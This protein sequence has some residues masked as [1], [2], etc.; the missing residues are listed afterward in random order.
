[1]RLLDESFARPGAVLAL[2]TSMALA[3][4]GC[5]M[6]GGSDRP[7]ASL[8]AGANAASQTANGPSA[9][10][11]VVLGD[12]FTIDG[13]EYVPVDSLNYDEVG[14]ATFDPDSGITA[15]H[16]TLPLPSY[17]EV[18]SLETG[19]T[20]LVRVERR[21]PMTGKRLIGLS[22]GAQ[23]QLGASEGTPVRV[24]RVN[25]QEVER[26]ALRAGQPAPERLATPMSLVAVLKRKLP[27]AGSTSLALAGEGQDSKQ[28][29]DTEE[30]AGQVQIAS[31]LPEEANDPH[32]AD[33]TGAQPVVAQVEPPTPAS[34]PAPSSKS[35]LVVQAA[36]FSS[37]ANAKRA[38]V[39]LDGFV[40]PS[41]KFYRVRTGPY[42][43]RGQANA[44]LAKVKSAGYSD[45][46]VITAG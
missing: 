40:V 25:P 33:E 44:A 8:S 45:A 7:A 46:R 36:T 3:L 2:T 23:A 18:T 20:I 22:A 30:I 13:V 5:G 32:S 37:E 27:A 34:N 19:E 12:P 35:G 21:G 11:P 29:P 26:A 39:A 24:R 14:Y 31:S 43:S 4:G 9:D 41:G 38:A 1:M 6:L 10:Y 28:E 16:K 42:T 15:S 17:A